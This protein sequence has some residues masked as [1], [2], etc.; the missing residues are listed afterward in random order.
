MVISNSCLYFK[1][2]SF[3]VSITLGVSITHPFQALF[4]ANFIAVIGL[5]SQCQKVSFFPN[6][7]RNITNFK[8]EKNEEKSSSLSW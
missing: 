8:S 5:Y 1:T 7:W 2:K 6:F 4:L 3:K